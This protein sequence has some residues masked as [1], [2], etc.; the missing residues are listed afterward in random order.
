MLAQVIDA[1]ASLRP[2][3]WMAVVLLALATAGILA[4][5]HT[6]ING[7]GPAHS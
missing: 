3:L 4:A 6:K 2:L 1:T 5:H 7:D